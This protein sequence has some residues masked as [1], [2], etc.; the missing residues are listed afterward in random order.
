MT[1]AT[2]KPRSCHQVWLLNQG[3]L[4]RSSY[5]LG[6]CRSAAMMESNGHGSDGV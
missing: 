1:R 2:S 3:L 4:L 5:G 6:H